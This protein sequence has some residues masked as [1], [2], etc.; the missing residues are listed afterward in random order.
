MQTQQHQ[1]IPIAWE[2]ATSDQKGLAQI[3][4]LTERITLAEGRTKTSAPFLTVIRNTRQTPPIPAVLSP[5]FWSR[6]H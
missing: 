6:D 2:E 3:I 4:S 1:S 5:S